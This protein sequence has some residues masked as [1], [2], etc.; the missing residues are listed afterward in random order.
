M[1]IILYLNV[2][3]LSLRLW[4]FI[5]VNLNLSPLAWLYKN[6]YWG[7][8]GPCLDEVPRYQKIKM[9]IELMLLFS[10]KWP[11]F[12]CFFFLYF[13]IYGCVIS[14]YKF[15][16]I[17]FSYY[18]NVSLIGCCFLI[19]LYGIYFFTVFSLYK[20]SSFITY[21]KNLSIWHIDM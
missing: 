21:Q 5:L 2:F 4:K 8:K 6:R 15:Y 20:L 11:F 18:L 7:S 1:I 12:P 3:G 13:P 17:N 10:Y 14:N 9:L 16:A 19:F